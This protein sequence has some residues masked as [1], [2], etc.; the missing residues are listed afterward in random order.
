MQRGD[1]VL[2][3]ATGIDWKAEILPV[4]IITDQDRPDLENQ[5]RVS[6]AG[7]NLGVPDTNNLDKSGSAFSGWDI[8]RQKMVRA[9]KGASLIDTT[10]AD[11]IYAPKDFPVD[12]TLGNDD[13]G[14]SADED[15][16]PYSA[17]IGSVG[18]LVSNDEPR[19]IFY[20]PQNST[21]SG[22]GSDGDKMHYQIRFKEF[23]RVQ[24]GHKWYRCSDV[25]DGLWRYFF[26]VVRS[27]GQ[28]NL[29]PGTTVIFD[30][31]NQ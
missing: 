6:P 26:N 1:Q 24:I 20:D 9:Q 8:S 13:A 30:L 19:S 4:D 22:T 2:Q 16:N 5:Q 31:T 10:A 12:N 25:N 15:D 17:D 11:G 21:H 27:S 28:W 3:I 29:E 14:V 23:V 18:E 7:A